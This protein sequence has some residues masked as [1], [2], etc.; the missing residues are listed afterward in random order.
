[1]ASIQQMLVIGGV[2]LLSYLV[3]SYHSSTGYQTSATLYNEAV[4][5]GT[6][7]AQSLM[8]EIQSKAF[9]EKTTAGTV[10]SP[11]SLTNPFDLGPDA[12]ENLPKKFDDV[13]DYN[14]YR[15]TVTHGRLG[16]F[17]AVVN[18]YYVN[19]MSPGSK[20]FGRTF[21]KRV[22]IYVNTYVLKD[23]LK[24]NHVISY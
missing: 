19:T 8:E 12:T 6:G 13:D 10:D 22:D 2:L 1:M 9:D 20:S 21:S 5:S 4:I 15:T 16:D 17:D 14:D 7:I 3:L 18:V 11:D 24:F 23:T